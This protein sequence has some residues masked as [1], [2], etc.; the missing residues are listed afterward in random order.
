MSAE[1]LGAVAGV[2]LSLA[3]SYIPGLSGKF[4]ALETTTKRLIMAGLL[5]V[6]AVGAL[7]LSCLNVVVTVD[8]SQSGLIGLINVY[9][10]ALVANQAMFVITKN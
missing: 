9:I 10:A 7:G 5:L 8:C 6:V 3:F 4:D 1:Q 2:L